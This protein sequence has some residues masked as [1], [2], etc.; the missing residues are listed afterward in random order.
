MHIQLEFTLDIKKPKSHFEGDFGESEDGTPH[1]ETDDD[2][3]IE[4]ENLKPKGEENEN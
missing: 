2:S 1:G 3:D 4:D